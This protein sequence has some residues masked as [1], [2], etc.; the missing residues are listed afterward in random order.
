[1][2]EGT[3]SLNKNN[4]ICTLLLNLGGAML[5]IGGAVI[6]FRYGLLPILQQG[7][8]LDDEGAG[9]LRRAGVFIAVVLGYITYVRM[10]E[11]RSPRELVFNPVPVGLGLFFGAAMI[12]FVASIL[13]GV[14][15]YEM[16]AYRG[17]QLGLLDI[18]FVIL[19]AAT[20][21]EIVFRAVLFAALEQRWGTV[22]ALWLQSLLF[23]VL[24]IAN[25]ADSVSILDLV[26]TVFSG[27]LIGVFWTLIFIYTRNVWVVA[28][29]HAGWNFA[30]VLTGLPLS[31][32]SDWQVQAPLQSIY[33]GP[34][35]LTGGSVGPE[36]SVLTIV[37]VLVS[38][39]AIFMF[40]QRQ[41]RLIPLR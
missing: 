19:V 35:W 6:A 28:A 29:H 5:F 37:L 38:S 33:H 22:K 4:R 40:A 2:T 15:V 41:Q 39:V 10:F 3:Y 12:V 26:I 25:L 31:G 18:A 27:T 20:I 34:N 9:L 24:H 36:D 23:S 8:Q 13:F 11:K 30:V 21:E 16:T 32:L 7:F 17:L 14:G 1:M